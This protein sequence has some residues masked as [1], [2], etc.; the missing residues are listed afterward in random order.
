MAITGLLFLHRSQAEAIW[1]FLGPV[2]E[3]FHK[4]QALFPYL[5]QELISPI[6][7]QGSCPA[8]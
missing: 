6:T 4:L 3:A 1:L 8:V 5:G 7:S 2:G